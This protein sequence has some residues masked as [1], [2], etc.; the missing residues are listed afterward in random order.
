MKVF[1]GA[2]A[3]GSSQPERQDQNLVLVLLGDI[4]I[5]GEI[6]LNLSGLVY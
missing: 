4:P 3:S 2:A 6:V 5:T 1:L